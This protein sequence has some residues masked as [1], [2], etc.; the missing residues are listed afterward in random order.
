MSTVISIGGNKG[1]YRRN[2]IFICNS[3]KLS[4][5]DI[6]G[7]HH[8]TSFTKLNIMSSSIIDLSFE[9]IDTSKYQLRKVIAIYKRE[10][11]RNLTHHCKNTNKYWRTNILKTANQRVLYRQSVHFDNNLY[12]WLSDGTHYSRQCYRQKF[13]FLWHVSNRRPSSIGNKNRR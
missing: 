3:R 4:T 9:G 10:K 11:N 12:R 8:G 5:T 13:N 6:K 2:S 1:I 7:I